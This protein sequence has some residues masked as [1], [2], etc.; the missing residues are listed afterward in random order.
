MRNFWQQ[1]AIATNWPV[2]GAVSILSL[3]GVVS[4][5]GDDPADGKKQLIFLFVGIGCMVAFQAVNYLH[6]GRY[7]W[8]FYGLSI[9]LILYTVVGSVVHVPGVKQ[10]NGACAWINFGYF[11]LQPSELLKIAFCMVMARY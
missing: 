2:L 1:L 5:W 10:I 7:A 6:L 3:A 8:G 4:I 9:L 11:S